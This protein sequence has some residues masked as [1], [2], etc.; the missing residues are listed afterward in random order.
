MTYQLA[1]ATRRADEWIIIDEEAQEFIL[2]C[3]NADAL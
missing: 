1:C 3:C 2:G